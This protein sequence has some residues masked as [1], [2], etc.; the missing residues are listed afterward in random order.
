MI[1][2]F[3]LLVFLL[4]SGFSVAHADFEK[5]EALM[6]QGDFAGALEFWLPMAEMGH[7]PSQH[8]VGE[9]YLEGICYPQSFESA[10]KWYSKSAEQGYAPAQVNLGELYEKGLGV[11]KDLDQ[12]Q[13]LYKSALEQGY[14]KARTRL[15]KL[16]AH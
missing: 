12:A 4:F 13:S 11:S 5:G 2:F 16:T 14:E 1:R 9:L 10:V 7:A 8:R 6:E 15:E 3:S